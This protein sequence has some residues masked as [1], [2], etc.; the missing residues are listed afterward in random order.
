MD[1]SIPIRLRSAD[2]VLTAPPWPVDRGCPFKCQIITIFQPMPFSGSLAGLYGRNKW[3]YFLLSVL[4]LVASFILPKKLIVI[5]LTSANKVFCK[6]A[7]SCL[8]FYLRIAY[9]SL[10]L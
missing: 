7:I 9:Y 8:L 3:I 4:L 2:S 10:S 6:C 1:L 5:A